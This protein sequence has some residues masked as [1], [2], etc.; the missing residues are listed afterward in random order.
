VAVPVNAI[1]FAYGS[2][3]IAVVYLGV[4]CSCS[5]PRKIGFWFIILYNKI[6]HHVK[7]LVRRWLFSIFDF[8]LERPKKLKKASRGPHEDDKFCILDE[9]K[10]SAENFDIL[11]SITLGI[12]YFIFYVDLNTPLVP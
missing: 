1:S 10:H 4:F 3:S 5:I 9:T 7:F 11:H 2:G 6:K 8:G 12:L